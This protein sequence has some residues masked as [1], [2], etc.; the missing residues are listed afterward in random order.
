MTLEYGDIDVDND[1]IVLLGFSTVPI[2][3]PTVGTVIGTVDG[4]DSGSLSFMDFGDGSVIRCNTFQDQNDGTPFGLYT[5]AGFIWANGGVCATPQ[6]G[7]L[8]VP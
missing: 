7:N 5:M 1:Q 6:S 4:G 2:A 3:G 8:I